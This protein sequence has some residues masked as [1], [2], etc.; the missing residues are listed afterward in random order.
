MENVAVVP[1]V[2][3]KGYQRVSG[4]INSQIR[5]ALGQARRAAVDKNAHFSPD[6]SRGRGK[7]ADRSRI[8]HNATDPSVRGFPVFWLNCRD[9]EEAAGAGRA[10]PMAPQSE[11]RS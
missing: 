4:L 11:Q 9:R 8:Q 10:T 1:A 3:D 5:A 6:L 2:L 7:I